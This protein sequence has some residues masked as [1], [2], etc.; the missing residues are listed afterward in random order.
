LSTGNI[1]QRAFAGPV[2]QI[3]S[4]LSFFGC[5]K[6][7]YQSQ[8]E[9][10][11]LTRFGNTNPDV[12][13]L[14]TGATQGQSRFQAFKSCEFNIAEAFGFSVKLVLH[15]ANTCDLAVSEEI[16]DVALCSIE[17]QIGQVSGIGRLCRKR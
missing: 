10:V 14:E 7:V 11:N 3:S 4:V 8:K 16:L 12:S 15:D 9:A 2:A 13:A 5:S 6:S 1:W 17:G